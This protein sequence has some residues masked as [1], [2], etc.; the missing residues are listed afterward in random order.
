M[1]RSYDPAVPHLKET[2]THAHLHATYKGGHCSIVCKA[3]QWKWPEYPSVGQLNKIA[4]K[5]LQTTLLIERKQVADQN[6]QY[7]NL[8][9]NNNNK[10]LLEYT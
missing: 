7:T 9:Q 3:K 5:D 4:W 6:I 8:L 1:Y 10:H 2:E